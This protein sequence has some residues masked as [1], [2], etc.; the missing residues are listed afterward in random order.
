MSRFDFILKHI[1]GKNMEQENSLSKKAD[2][3]EDVER[4]NK[5]QVMVEEGV[6]RN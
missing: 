4:D 3:A 6:V 5:N 1:A 2:W